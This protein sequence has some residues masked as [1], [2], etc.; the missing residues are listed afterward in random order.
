MPTIY[1][2]FG[3][4]TTHPKRWGV[5]RLS[6]PRAP[7]RWSARLV[8]R[9]NQDVPEIFVNVCRR[10]GEIYCEE[11]IRK[12]KTIRSIRVDKR[13]SDG[14]WIRFHDLNLLLYRSLRIEKVEVHQVGVFTYPESTIIAT[15]CTK[16]ARRSIKCYETCTW[17]KL[18]DFTVL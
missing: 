5:P 12:F 15:S 18:L 9:N 13:H 7:S 3:P 14:V 2:C 10:G 1:I 11:F 4:I 6:L 8:A 17:R 16:E